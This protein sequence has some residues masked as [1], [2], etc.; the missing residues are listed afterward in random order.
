M[1]GTPIH[2]QTQACKQDHKKQEPCWLALTLASLAGAWPCSNRAGEGARLPVPPQ[3][4]GGRDQRG[5]RRGGKE[6]EAE[7][8]AD[9][10][11]S[12]CGVWEVPQDKGCSAAE[13]V[14]GVGVLQ[15]KCELKQVVAC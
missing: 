1:S 4:R 10:W 14:P 5:D 11:V 2:N 12:W 9:R 15:L 3:S 6:G 8:D 13:R 7:A